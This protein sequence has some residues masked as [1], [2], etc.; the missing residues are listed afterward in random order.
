MKYVAIFLYRSNIPILEIRPMERNGEIMEILKFTG[1]QST[2]SPRRSKKLSLFVGAAALGGVAVLGST[3]AANI[4]LNGGT[5]VEF[6]QGVALTSACDSDGIT[7]TPTATFINA[8]NG[9]SF[10][11]T[12]VAFSGISSNCIEKTFTLKAY[13]DTSSTPLNLATVSSAAYNQATFKYTTSATVSGGISAS[14][15]A[16]YSGTY[17]LGFAGTQATSGAVSKLTLESQ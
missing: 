15:I 3:L 17:T 16:V 6:G 14:N 8:A 7:A 13:G 2:K 10:N 4:S 11:F 12:T 1:A 9:G 5:G